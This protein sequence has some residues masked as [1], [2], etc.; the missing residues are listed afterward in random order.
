LDLI[1]N[2]SFKGR[3]FRGEKIFWFFAT[4]FLA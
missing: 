4:L 1:K 3:F 2:R